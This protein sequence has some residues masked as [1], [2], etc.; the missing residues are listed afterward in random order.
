MTQIDKQVEQAPNT[1]T[2][3]IVTGEIPAMDAVTQ[4]RFSAG[5][6]TPIS[7]GNKPLTN[8]QLKAIRNRYYKFVSSD[9]FDQIYMTQKV[10][11]ELYCL[12]WCKIHILN[13][14]FKLMKSINLQNYANSFVKIESGYFIVTNGRGIFV[15]SSDGAELQQIKLGSF[16]GAL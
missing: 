5:Q 2:A 14:D 7:S 8:S 4:L 3:D 15:L 1:F 16:H 12:A 13:K 10:N 6:P 9:D 11:E